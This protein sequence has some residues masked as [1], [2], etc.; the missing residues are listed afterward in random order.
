MS[1]DLTSAL[2]SGIQAAV[3]RPVFLFE[4]EFDGGWVRVWSGLGDLAWNGETWTGIGTLGA[5]SDIEETDEVRAAGVT[6][7]L[8]GVP[9][10]M[11]ALALSSLRQ[12]RTGRLWF[13]LFDGEADSLIADPYLAFEGRLDVGQIDEQADPRSGAASSIVTLKYENVLIALERAKERRYTH[14]DQQLAY[15]GDRGFEY[16]PS[17][18]DAQIT[19]GG[20]ASGS[21]T[22]TGFSSPADKMAS[23]KG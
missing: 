10:E 7:S 17:L 19:W 12:N 20:S 23:I 3:V 8:S 1:R 16:I 18:Q 11:V 4:G 2:A 21:G 14:E 13:A 15:A 9:P 5:I 6:V 22:G